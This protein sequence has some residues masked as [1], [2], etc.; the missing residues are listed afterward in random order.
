MEQHTLIRLRKL[1][2]VTDLL[3]APALDVTQRDDRASN[4]SS[5][6]AR[7]G[8]PQWPSRVKREGSTAG[9]RP[10]SSSKEENG[11]LRAS[12]T[13]RVFAVFATMR[14]S[15]VLSDERPSNLSMPLSTPSHASWTT[16]SATARLETYI[17]ATRSIA[18]PYM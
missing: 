17:C 3:C 9:S 7:G 11:M 6:H 1:E 14:K 10:L 13:P 2:S 16:S 5:G 15:H 8:I 18:G 4:R 12:R